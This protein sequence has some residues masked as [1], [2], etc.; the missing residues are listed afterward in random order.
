V[1]KQWL[2]QN[3]LERKKT[4]GFEKGHV[5]YGIISKDFK[6]DPNLGRKEK[7]REGNGMRLKLL[8]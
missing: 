3:E 5:I 6:F 7:K 1:S 4:M 2:I 8:I